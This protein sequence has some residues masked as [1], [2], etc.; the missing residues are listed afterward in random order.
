MAPEE[1]GRVA[2]WCAAEAAAEEGNSMERITGRVGYALAYMGES[3]KDPKGDVPG[4]M[5]TQA[6]MDVLGRLEQYENTGLEPGEIAGRI[7]SAECKAARA[8][9]VSEIMRIAGLMDAIGSAIGVQITEDLA[10]RT[11]GA[12]ASLARMMQEEMAE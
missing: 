2:E 9:K 5:S 4:E 12:A 8:A 7:F 10:M 11:A 1:I 6:V 3:R